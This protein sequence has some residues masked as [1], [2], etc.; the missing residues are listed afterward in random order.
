MAG[1]LTAAPAISDLTRLRAGFPAWTITTFTV[2]TDDH[3]VTVTSVY[4]QAVRGGYTAVSPDPGVLRL[5][6]RAYDN[7]TGT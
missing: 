6:M 2:T 5:M 7:G 1:L 4:W 3:G